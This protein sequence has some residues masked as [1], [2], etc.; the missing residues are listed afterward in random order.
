MPNSYFQFKKFTVYHD[1]C[2]MKVGTDGVLLGIWTDTTDATN[3]L[4]IG[5]GTGLI[6]LML[7]Q[8]SNFQTNIAT[9][10]IDRGAY[11]QTCENVRNSPFENISCAHISLQEYASLHENASSYDLI[12]SNPPY[13]SESLHSPDEQRT[14]ARHTGSL[15]LDTFFSCVA[16]LLSKDGKLSIVYPYIEKD[17]LI[18]LASEFGLYPS[19]VTRVYPVVNAQAKRIL[20]EFRKDK[21]TLIENDLAIEKERHIYTD[22]FIALAKDFY[23]KM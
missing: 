13:F 7:A 18:R 17:K 4:D 5:S 16:K 12:A 20:L 1:K 15:D 21:K 22:E 19:R 10:D 9:I 2:A 3:I 23:L 11:L 14:L 8:R 6:A